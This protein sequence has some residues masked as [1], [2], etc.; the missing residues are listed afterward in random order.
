[1]EWL[2]VA[3]FS[4]DFAACDN[5]SKYEITREKPWAVDKC[6]LGFWDLEIK[7]FG[8]TPFLMTPWVVPENGC[9]EYIIMSHESTNLLSSNIFKKILQKL[10]HSTTALN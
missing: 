2:F 5:H 7:K 6:Y 10:A 9:K 8:Q 1:L 4:A 3:Y